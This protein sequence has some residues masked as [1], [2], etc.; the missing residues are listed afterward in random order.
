MSSASASM[1]A[2]F[3]VAVAVAIG[4]DLGVF[5]RGPRRIRLKA[6]LLE[7]AAW[8]AVSLAF[9]LWVYVSRGREA[10]MQFLAGYVIEK[11]L[12]VDNILVFGVIFR[13]LGVPTESQ[14]R[15]LY[16]GVIGALLMRALFVIGGVQLLSHF[17]SILY[18]LGALLLLTGLRMIYPRARKIQS[19]RSWLVRIVRRVVPM[20]EE[21]HGDEF[22]VRDEAQWTA[23]PLLLTLVAI[24]ITDIIFAVDSVPAVLAI[25]RDTFIAYSSNVFAVLGL[26][27]MYFGLAEILPRLRFLHH[28]LAAVLI[29]VGT[30]MLVANWRAISTEA[31]LAAIGAILALTAV[32]SFLWPAGN[33]NNARPR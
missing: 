33:A 13:G 10:G 21:F 23:T 31:S 30:K 4:V 20:T 5:H 8:I 28:G 1:W 12:S 22:I 15:V 9:N 32:A 27:A 17:R 3:G 14:H 16:G 18:F 25:T 24:E 11:S 19:E 26:R 7:T 6:A 29:F 2:I